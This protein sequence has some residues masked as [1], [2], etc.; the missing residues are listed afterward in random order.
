[1]RNEKKG[2]LIIYH[3]CLLDSIKTVV[4]TENIIL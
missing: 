1:M 4:V 3:R 2:H